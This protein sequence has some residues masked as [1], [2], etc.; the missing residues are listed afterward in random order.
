MA[1]Y[2]GGPL[3]VSEH[4]SLVGRVPF[5]IMVEEIGAHETRNYASKVT[6]HLI[7]YVDLYASDD[8]RTAI[9]TGLLPPIEL[10][11]PKN[12]IHF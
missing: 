7:R 2:N 10:P 9:L 5:D 4:M 11:M 3:R 8:E 1:A 12:E 6:D